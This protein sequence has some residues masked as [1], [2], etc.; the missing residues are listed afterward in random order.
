MGIGPK[1]D[2]KSFKKLLGFSLGL[3]IFE[4]WPLELIPGTTSL[5]AFPAARRT[6]A[7]NANQGGTSKHQPVQEAGTADQQ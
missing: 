1:K 4:L 3:E 6:S 2:S 5:P 7:L